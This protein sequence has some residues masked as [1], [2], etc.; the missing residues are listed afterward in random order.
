MEGL[1]LEEISELIEEFKRTAGTPISTEYLFSTGES[2]GPK[3][4][5]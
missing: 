4:T 5:L 2:S 3:I 1:I